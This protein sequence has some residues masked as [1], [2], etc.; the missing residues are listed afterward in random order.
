MFFR[1]IFLTLFCFSAQA[2]DKPNLV[3]L[4]ID[5]TEQ[6]SELEAEYGAALQEGLQNRYTVFYGASVEKELE[7]EYGKIDCDAETCNQNIAIAFNG[8]LIADGAVKRIDGGYLLKLVVSN[9]LTSEV[10]ETRTEPCENC[11]QFSVIN[12]LKKI[13]RGEKIDNSGTRSSS[14]GRTQVHIIE[15]EAPAISVKNAGQR[16][17]LIF[18]TQPSGAKIK[19]NGKDKGVTPYQGLNHK[20][21]DSIKILID[22]QY[23]QPFELNLELQQAITQLDTVTLK[24]GTA[25]LFVAS[26]P[27][28]SN[29]QVY[30]NGEAKGAAPQFINVETGEYNVQVKSTLQSSI[31]STTKMTVGKQLNLTLPLT[32]SAQAT[33]IKNDLSTLILNTKPQGVTVTLKG[34]KLGITPLQIL[35]KTV[36]DSL[37]LTFDKKYHRSVTAKIDLNETI[38]RVEGIELSRAK[39]TVLITTNPFV[40]GG[41]VIIDGKSYG[42]VPLNLEILAGEYEVQVKAPKQ[43]TKKQRFEVNAGNNDLVSLGFGIQTGERQAV[44]IVGVDFEFVNIPAGSFRMGGSEDWSVEPIH[45]VNVSS[46]DMMSTEVT[47]GQWQAIMGNDPT[48]FK[49][50]GGNVINNSCPV[51][52]VSWYDIQEFIKK[53]NQKTGKVY[54]LPSEAEWEYAARAGSTTHYSWGDKIGKNRAN[55]YDCGSQW[56]GKSTAPV[57]SFQPNAF[58]LYDMHGNVGE[59]MQD[60]NNGSYKGAPSDGSPWMKGDCRLAVVRGG[61]FLSNA[62]FVR[63]T[64]RWGDSRG[65]RMNNHGFRL[66]QGF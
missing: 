20:I 41:E 32:G 21:G 51:E 52:K 58:G 35:N 7:K 6:D 37:K 56:D 18:D 40:A 26:T 12:F 8:E 22:Q 38:N 34:K 65:S 31:T 24:K 63:S 44:E 5:V 48:H 1:M 13:G 42:K 11:N 10:I 47:Q 60:C 43:S 19:I 61:G 29:S 54:R 9:V 27:Y 46:F 62:T 45:T 4:P 57:A 23:Y 33:S 2:A 25:R 66:I 59:W 53:L 39:G 17:I 49:S 36:G 14:N 28:I 15:S 3:L 30:I 55:C 50:C 64:I 16:G